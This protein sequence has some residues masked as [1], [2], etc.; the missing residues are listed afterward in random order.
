VV[1]PLIPIGQD[2]YVHQ[3]G[4][5]RDI[6]YLATPEQVQYYDVKFKSKGGVLADESGLGKTIEIIGLILANPKTDV[7]NTTTN[8]ET[9]TELRTK[10]T[11]V[12]CNGP[13]ISHWKN[14]LKQFGVK[15]LIV[16]SIP[17]AGI[18][19]KF[20]DKNIFDAGKTRNSL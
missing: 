10:A 18:E 8:F 13:R 3:N 16:V 12:V 15:N 14:T 7:D 2:I 9:D 4:P 11:L 17:T 1:S 20:T 5:I 6:L 19:Q